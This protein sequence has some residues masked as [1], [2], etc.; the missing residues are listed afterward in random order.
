MG[1][2]CPC[3]H[4]LSMCHRENAARWCGSSRPRCDAPS[5]DFSVICDLFPLHD[6]PHMNAATSSEWRQTG[7]GSDAADTP[8]T[9]KGAL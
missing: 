1:E 2:R 7:A 6:G 9:K 5:P 8:H 4:V 3:G